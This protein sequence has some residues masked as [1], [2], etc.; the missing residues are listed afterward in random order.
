[1]SL[2]QSYFVV[3]NLLFKI[4]MG[5][6]IVKKSL[7]KAYGLYGVPQPSLYN[8]AFGLKTKNSFLKI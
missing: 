7:S 1:M 4:N 2:K 8:S 3:L 6:T 5:K